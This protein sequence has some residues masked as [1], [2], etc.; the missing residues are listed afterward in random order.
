MDG[1]W[2]QQFKTSEQ[3]QSQYPRMKFAGWPRAGA[4]ASATRVGARRAARA[5]KDAEDTWLRGCREHALRGVT[6]RPAGRSPASLHQIPRPKVR[7]PRAP[8]GTQR[9]GSAPAQLGS[10]GKASR[11]RSLNNLTHTH[12][13]PT[14]PS[15]HQPWQP[16][17]AQ[18]TNW[19]RW[20][21]AKAGPPFLQKRAL[22][23]TPAPCGSRVGYSGAHSLEDELVGVLNHRLQGLQE[24]CTGGG[25]ATGAHGVVSRP[26]DLNAGYRHMRCQLTQ[27]CKWQ[28]V[29]CMAP[30][31]P[32]NSIR[33]NTSEHWPHC[34]TG[35]THLS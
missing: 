31:V 35:T 25:G 5:K 6:R 21:R 28:L 19:L 33:R 10:T 26:A 2:L 12:L 1:T 4:A 15:A 27:P 7:E 13:F 14:S 18:D 11:S 23:P 29:L 20:A 24:L 16:A 8:A 34:S 3:Q 17:A 32:W 9:H 30:G 22:Q